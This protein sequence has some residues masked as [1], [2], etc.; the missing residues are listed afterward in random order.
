MPDLTLVQNQYKIIEN[1][2]KKGKKVLIQFYNSQGQHT[3]VVFE[4]GF[5]G[6][7]VV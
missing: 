2:F 5:A 3:R 4:M 6:T 7:W 1:L